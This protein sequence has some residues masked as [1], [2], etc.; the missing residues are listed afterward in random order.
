MADEIDAAQAHIEREEAFRRKYHNADRL[1]ALPT[2]KCLNC[3][4]PQ[5]DRRW[6]DDACRSDWDKRRRT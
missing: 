6:C 5:P 4:E 3:G 1:D 2:G